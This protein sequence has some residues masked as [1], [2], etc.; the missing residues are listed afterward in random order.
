[1]ALHTSLNGT[2]AEKMRIT[3]AGN[4]G[5]GVTPEAIVSTH[6]SL[7]LGGNGYWSSYGTQGASGEMDF[8]HNLYNSA[9]GT[10]KYISTDEATLY[11]QGSGKHTFKSAASGSADAAISFTTNMILDVNSRISL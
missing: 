6:N 3:S 11:R 10:P 9:A 8:G 2:L 1:M 5:I 7:Q 4:V